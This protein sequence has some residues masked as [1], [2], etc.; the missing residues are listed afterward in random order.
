M[1]LT[2]RDQ[3]NMLIVRFAGSFPLHSQAKRR[4]GTRHQ[5]AA[6]E[7]GTGA[8]EEAGRGAQGKDLEYPLA[9]PLLG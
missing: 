1:V 2:D 4:G 3:G 5:M 6:A 9:A 7:P 8:V